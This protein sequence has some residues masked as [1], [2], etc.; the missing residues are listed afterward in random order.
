[1]QSSPV[2]LL[3]ALPVRG[4]FVS[5]PIARRTSKFQTPPVFEACIS[6]LCIADRLPSYSSHALA[7]QRRGKRGP[8]DH[9]KEKGGGGHS[10]SSQKQKLGL[11]SNAP[12]VILTTTLHRGPHMVKGEKENFFPILENG[13]RRFVRVDTLFL[14]GR[15]NLAHCLLDRKWR[16]FGPTLASFNGTNG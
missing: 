8:S 14:H 12:P 1:M 7:E 9:T 11:S 10:S 3:D 13:K 16:F 15:S 5:P 6:V 4:C 2:S